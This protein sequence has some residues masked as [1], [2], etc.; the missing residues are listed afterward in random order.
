M[1]N[2]KLGLIVSNDSN[3]RYFQ[4]I[5]FFFIGLDGLPGDQGISGPTGEIG[6]YGLDGVKGPPGSDGRPG[7]PGPKGLRVSF[8]LYMA[9]LK[10]TQRHFSC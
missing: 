4:K 7:F 8:N 2:L 5:Y 10:Y 1:I 3:K 9:I 6:Q